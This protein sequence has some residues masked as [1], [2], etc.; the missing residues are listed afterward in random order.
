MQPS[1][2]LQSSTAKFAEGARFI[3]AFAIIVHLVW[4]GLLLVDGTA[5]N[6]TP[7][8]ETA[9][10]LGRYP[11]AALFFVV[12]ILAT[13]AIRLKNPWLL[14]PQQTVMLAA[15]TGG[16]FAIAA[17]AYADGTQRNPTFIAADQFPVIAAT[18]LHTLAVII[19]LVKV[20][21]D[22]R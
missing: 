11:T 7:I 8:H 6:T 3:F 1:R 14:L 10:A 13:V 15:T 9:V 20:E 22:A 4:A 18:L 19:L 16:L 2:P 21:Q 17:G 12:A 5:V